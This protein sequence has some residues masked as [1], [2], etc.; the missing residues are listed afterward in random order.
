MQGGSLMLPGLLNN[1]KIQRYYGVY[2]INNSP[3]I[4]DKPHVINI[5]KFQSIVTHSNTL[6]VNGNNVI[7]FDSFGIQYVS[8][9]IRKFIGNKNI[10][11]NIYIIKA[12]ISIIYG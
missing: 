2:S 11:T 3:K 9:E 10:I 12:H 7:Y 6:Y 5:D 8:N 4:K 1:F